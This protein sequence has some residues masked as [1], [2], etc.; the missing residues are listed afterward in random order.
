MFGIDCPDKSD[1]QLIDSPSRLHLNV[2]LQ[3]LRRVTFE[4]VP[5]MAVLGIGNLEIEN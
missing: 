1:L 2:I 3:L 5:D 4:F